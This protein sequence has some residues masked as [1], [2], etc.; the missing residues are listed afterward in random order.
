MILRIDGKLFQLRSG[1]QDAWTA[2]GA[3]DR[4]IVTAMRTGT[5]M[6]VDSRS[7]RGGLIRDRYHLRGAATAVDAAAIACTRT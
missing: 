6:V 4:Q 7:V 2:N 1:G 5:E 3:A